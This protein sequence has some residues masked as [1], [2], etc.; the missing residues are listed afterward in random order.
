MEKIMR[1]VDTSSKMSKIKYLDED[2]EHHGQIFR[3][4]MPFKVKKILLASSLYDAFVIE[5]EGLIS[6]M[7][8][9][10]YRD[11]N[12]SSPPH[13]TRVSSGREALSKLKEQQYDL[14]I[15]MSKNIDMNPFD[16]GKKIKL[17][18]PNL[19]VILLAT[20]VAG[21]HL[22]QQRINDDGIDK[23]FFWK[24]DSRL[25]LAIIKY[26]EDKINAQND[27]S[28][29][30][31]RVIILLEDSIEYYSLFLPI[32]YTEIVRQTRRSL[33]EDLNET[34]R[35]LRRRARPKIL[36]T[37]TFEESLKLFEYYREYVL[38][39]ISDVIF[40]HKGKMDTEAGYKLV[41]SIKRRSTYQL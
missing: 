37:E 31:V 18:Y 2:Y 26:V 1:R 4:L 40:K 11:L 28:I 5:E 17:L 36:L 21:L 27:T 6:E 15:T 30:N 39:V 33:S 19:P 14:V 35:L 38:G 8:I 24:G 32:I 23:T 34:Q 9:R 13:V 22:S 3:N 20:D 25:I 7:V 10:E 12:L 16:F 41:N 29:G